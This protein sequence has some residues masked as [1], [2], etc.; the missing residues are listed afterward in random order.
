VRRAR[1]HRQFPRRRGHQTHSRRLRLHARLR[2]PATTAA[3]SSRG[4]SGAVRA[5]GRSS[6]TTSDGAADRSRT[7]S[8]PSLAL[9]QRRAR[10][11]L[12]PSRTI[13][14]RSTSRRGSSSS[15]NTVH[16]VD[17]DLDRVAV[18][19]SVSRWLPQELRH[20]SSI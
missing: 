10:E 11:H 13:P 6:R 5:S 19:R 16:Q 1:R 8:R 18:R 2:A 9:R 7:S 3:R 12:R 20:A 14:T 17:A 4:P 15:L